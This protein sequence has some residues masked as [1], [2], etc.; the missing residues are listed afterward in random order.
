MSGLL[1]RNRSTLTVLICFLVALFEGIDLQAAG[2]AAPQ[3][4]PLFKLTP[5]QAGQFFSA[6]TLG[7]LIGAPLSGL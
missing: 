6:S 4:I 2:V 3:I 5:V 7:L 1:E